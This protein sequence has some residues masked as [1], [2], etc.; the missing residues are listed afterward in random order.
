MKKEKFYQVVIVL[1]LILNFG[2]LG[3][4]WLHHGPGPGPMP[5]RP[6][7]LI[8]EKLHL[9]APQKDKFETLKHEHHSQ[10]VSIQEAEGKLH[11][12]LFELLKKEP[13][14]SNQRNILLLELQNNDMQK[15]LVTFEHFRKLRA[16]LHPGQMNDFDD[17]VAELSRHL[18]A[19]HGR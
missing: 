13:V 6:D 2:I 9:D 3:F 14:D 7:R 19:P 4:M 1:L 8:F 12:E 11:R 15:E 5:G 16:I 17:F 18:L 10:M